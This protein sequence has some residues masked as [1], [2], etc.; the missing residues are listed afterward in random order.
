M[1]KIWLLGDIATDLFLDITFLGKFNNIVSYSKLA[2]FRENC[3]GSENSP[4]SNPSKVHSNV[5]LKW[6]Q[7]C[8]DFY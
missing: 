6:P 3:H 8:W 5:C 7:M 1:I 2:L 4:E